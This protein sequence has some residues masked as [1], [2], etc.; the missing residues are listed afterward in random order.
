[1]ACTSTRTLGV[2]LA[3]AL[4]GFGHSAPGAAVSSAPEAA[5]DARQLYA[6]TLHAPSVLAFQAE[7]QL[8]AQSRRSGLAPTAPRAGQTFDPKNREVQ[9]YRQFLAD[10]RHQLLAAMSSKIQR[11]LTPNQHWDL[12]GNGFSVSLTATEAA[13]LSRF[14]DIADLHA[15]PVLKPLPLST[16]EIRS[17]INAGL[18][19]KAVSSD[20][21]GVVVGIVGSGI[22]PTLAAFSATSSDGYTHQNPRG[23][24]FGLCVDTPAAVRCNDKLIGM[25]DFVNEA[26][27]LGID[28]GRDL[29][30][31]STAAA[32]IIAGNPVAGSI[33][34]AGTPI[35]ITHVGVAP[36][37]NLI[38]YKMFGGPDWTGPGVS[39][40]AVINQAVQDQVDVLVLNYFTPNA[41][42]PWTSQSEQALLQARAAGTL[43][44]AGF[45]GRTEQAGEI[46]GP[47]SA[48]WVMDSGYAVPASGHRAT[49][50][51]IRGPGLSE[52]FSLSGQSFSPSVAD[53]ELILSADRANGLPQCGTLNTNPSNPSGANNPFPLGS[54]AGM[55]VVCDFY[56]FSVAEMADNAKAA[57]AVGMVVLN[58]NN[59]DARH[60]TLM[61]SSSLPFVHL[62]KLDGDRLR[63]A[64]VAARNLNGRLRARIDA[65][66]VQALPAAGVLP[67]A[68]SDSASRVYNGVLKPN[69]VV[70][71][72]SIFAAAIGGG[73]YYQIGYSLAAS[74]VAAGMAAKVMSVRP[75]WSL[76]QVES[77]LHLTATDAR[78]NGTSPVLQAA[79]G[80]DAGSGVANADL[81]TQAGLH[82]PITIDDFQSANPATG[83]DPTQLNLPSIY[84]RRC[85]DV[86]SFTRR[87]AANFAGSW[88]IQTEGNAHLQLEVTPSQFSLQANETVTLTINARL[89]N[90][91]NVGAILNGKVLFVSSNNPTGTTMDMP[92][93]ILPGAGD[94]ANAV[95]LGAQA[96]LGQTEI[97]IPGLAGF[98]QVGT[99]SWPLKPL[100]QQTFQVNQNGRVRFLI[101]KPQFAANQTEGRLVVTLNSATA[102]DLDLYV[103]RDL[104]DDGLFGTG[105]VPCQSATTASAE[106]CE[107]VTDW[108]TDDPYLIEVIGYQASAAGDQATLGI[109]NEVPAIDPT[110]V[111]LPAQGQTNTGQ[112][113]RARAS[114]DLSNIPVQT[115]AV[116]FISFRDS[117]S[118]AKTVRLNISRAD[119][120]LPVKILSAAGE[121]TDLFLL[122]GQ[123]HE[124]MFVDVP[125]N[126]EALIIRTEPAPG[127]SGGNVDLYVSRDTNTTLPPAFPVAP[128]RTSQ[129]FRSTGNTNLETVA[130][131]GGNLVPGRYFITPMNVGTQATRTRVVVQAS[132]VGNARQPAANGYFNPQRSGHGVFLAKTPQVWALAWYTF[133]S[134][135]KPIW[136]T[137]QGAAASATAGAWTAP[138]YRSTWNGE[139]DLPQ[140]VGRVSLTFDGSDGFIYSWNLEGQAGSERLV[141]IGNPVCANGTLS[142]GGGWLRPDQSGWGSYFLNFAGNFEAE[143]IYVYDQDGLPR[144]VIGDGTFAPTLTKTLY[145]VRGFC[146]T[147]AF[148]PT[149]QQAVGT[150][151]RTLITGTQGR[152]S[153]QFSL[154]DGLVGSW[155]QQD[156]AWSKLTPDLSCSP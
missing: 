54:L 95:D 1:M 72:D 45:D 131:E 144:W 153:S 25:Y 73:A 31:F 24:R 43:V 57:G 111:V 90:R 112:A 71:A 126:T 11:N 105:E 92:V 69:L 82:F 80:S 40:L 38:T 135:G 76:A 36:R 96:T 55:I 60:V 3:M 56:A 74:S 98:D 123:A 87:V 140:D 108:T 129:P 39:S 78:L 26:G 61:Q 35:A 124:Q 44:V 109:Y 142:V 146:P 18:P 151:T 7:T 127:E 47:G 52:P 13:Q 17:Q 150:A 136:Y 88:T 21:E 155:L 118:I 84:T 28:Q 156:V 138:L 20:G 116:S 33:N 102:P 75:E 137:A 6:V 8:P 93:V 12:I 32:S 59:F 48:P 34:A 119:S 68:T 27:A 22:D 113:L 148:A 122:P 66:S 130:L 63:S 128:A 70:P 79:A 67:Y 42:N 149:S 62:S 132:F 15:E 121:S 117:V 58:N 120:T 94:S 4:A 10:Q 37:A 103:F 110:M 46:N 154:A 16:A 133:D 5:K 86:C 49:V 29:A 65:S 139:R 145:Q 85:L 152:F 50:T 89:L 106:S 143:A 77:A 19:G 81:A 125:A 51:D 9:A 100:A 53:A 101:N 107:L 83:G 147:C 14:P 134:A 91:P 115:P 2:C 114:W 30:G 99:V 64:M 141:P 97:Q 104:T 41:T 23:R